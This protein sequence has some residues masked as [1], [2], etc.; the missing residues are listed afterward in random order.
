MTPQ[1][2][3]NTLMEI[4][5]R[6][7]Q[8]EIIQKLETE[9]ADL[10][11]NGVTPC[12]A[13][14]TLGSEETWEAYVGQKIKL[15]SRLGIETKLVSLRPKTTEEVL[16]V[17]ERLDQDNTIHGLIVQRPFPT[18][19]DTERVIQSISNNKDID[20]FREDSKFEVPVWL[21]VSYIIT[22]I[23]QLSN[24]S[25]ASNWLSNQSILVVGKG[26]TAG[27]PVI[28]AL[29]KANLKPQVL[30]SKT[31]DR[32][33]LIANADI[34]ISATGKRGIIKEDLLKTNCILIGIGLHRENGA[35]VGD[36][37]ESEAKKHAKYY[38]PTPGGVGP[39]NLA[40]LFDNLIKSSR[41]SLDKKFDTE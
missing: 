3:Y 4:N 40:F 13:I 11:K 23:A 35:L 27:F 24:V 10:K 26:E 9:I 21:A 33:N 29:Q 39:L 12:I 14:V 32:D 19:I 41:S 34:I 22:H 18:Y 2:R 16:T 31:E 25:N 8:K 17:I 15:A 7:L 5:G 38:T 30:D 1:L 28:R 37:D 6:E 36:Y 20:G